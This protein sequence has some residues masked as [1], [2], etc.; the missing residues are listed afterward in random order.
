MK[1]INGYTNI[2]GTTS[3]S[4]P[5]S[6][7]KAQWEEWL[8]SGTS[9]SIINVSKSLHMLSLDAISMATFSSELSSLPH[10]TDLLH[11]LSNPPSET[12]VLLEVLVNVFPQLLNLP[13][14]MKNWAT[15]FKKELGATAES[16]WGE[17]ERGRGQKERGQGGYSKI[18]DLMG[19]NFITVLTSSYSELTPLLERR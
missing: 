19:E 2:T 6:Q 8:Q 3:L 18:L 13:S 16:V 11:K 7:V 4:F 9:S 15:M 10:I 1:P 12:P 17:V 14:E 5:A